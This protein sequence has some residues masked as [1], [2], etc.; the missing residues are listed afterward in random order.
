MLFRS[1]LIDDSEFHESG[2]P[3]KFSFFDVIFKNNTFSK[4][5]IHI[6][7]SKAHLI[8]SSDNQ[9]I[10]DKLISNI[11]N[12][13][14]YRISNIIFK[15]V[16]IHNDDN[17]NIPNDSTINLIKLKTVSPIVINNYDEELYLS[18]IN[19][20]ELFIN[21]LK[22]N[23]I[24]KIGK[25]SDIDIIIDKNTIKQKAVNY[26]GGLIIG[27]LFDFKI[28]SNNDVILKS[29]YNGFGSKNAIGFGFVKQ[30]K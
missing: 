24:T 20:E 10:L 29:Y 12:Q 14:V 2:L 11:N 17:I 8:I 22:K 16:S 13:K 21:G 15:I 3:N 23:I 19:D 7:E 4:D 18:L 28:I 6:S 25:P 9:D 30:I 1:S 26:K 27:F 5:G